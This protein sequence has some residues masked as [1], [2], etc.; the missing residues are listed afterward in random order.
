[1]TGLIK[2]FVYTHASVIMQLLAK[3][4]KGGDGK[5]AYIIAVYSAW[6]VYN[7]VTCILPI[8]HGSASA[9]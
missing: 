7:E 5:V 2:I 4:G 8:S 6:L 3:L 9:R 1:M